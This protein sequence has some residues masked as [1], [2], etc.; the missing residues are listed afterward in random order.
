MLYNANMVCIFLSTLYLT[1]R[2]ITTLLYYYITKLDEFATFQTVINTMPC[3]LTFVL[4]FQNVAL[5]K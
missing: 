2:C 5:L 1:L 4:V 3:I